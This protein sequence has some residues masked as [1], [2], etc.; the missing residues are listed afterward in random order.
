MK[1]LALVFTIF[2]FS[3]LPICAATVDAKGSLNGFG[4]TIHFGMDVKYTEMI[5]DEMTFSVNVDAPS[6]KRNKT[7]IDLRY[8]FKSLLIFYGGGEFKHQQDINL[9]GVRG[10]VGIQHPEGKVY[11]ELDG[12]GY[13]PI[14]MEM[15]TINFNLNG[16]I[17]WRRETFDTYFNYCFERFETSMGNVQNT[18]FLDFYVRM[19]SDETKIFTIVDLGLSANFDSDLN[20]IFK[21]RAGIKLGVAD[22]MGTE[23]IFGFEVNQ[24][25]DNA[26]VPIA[27]TAGWK[28]SF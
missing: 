17:G 7:R 18:N 6:T 22:D 16:R 2:I 9:C 21:M 20:D 15:E 11:F 13:I 26:D 10:G 24:E 1:K 5:S 12:M 3:L 23:Y 27:L 28:F 4:G 8:L 14:A 19:R 25:I